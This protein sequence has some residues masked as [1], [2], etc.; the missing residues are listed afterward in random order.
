MTLFDFL[1][2]LSATS[3]GLI[4]IA[5]VIAII[6]GIRVYL[7]AEGYAK[8][9]YFRGTSKERRCNETG[10]VAVG[11]P[12]PGNNGGFQREIGGLIANVD[13]LVTSLKDH[14]D[15]S[16]TVAYD[17]LRAH[18]RTDENEEDRHK[19]LRKSIDELTA[20]VA[21]NTLE[22]QTTGAKVDALRV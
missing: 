15:K 12:N 5:V 1:S 13:A 10:A 11:A 4:L 16:L 2:Q 6:V 21:A 17:T 3:F 9:R 19:R 20:A 7:L 8:R 18:E 22:T 14:H